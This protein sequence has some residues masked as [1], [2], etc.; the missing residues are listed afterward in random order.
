[1]DAFN[2]YAYSFMFLRI[3]RNRRGKNVYEY[4]QICERYRENG[5][6][7]TKILEYLGPVRD[8]SDMERYRRALL[9]AGEKQSIIR[10]TPEGVLSS[11]FDGVWSHLCLHGSDEKQW[12]PQYIE[13]ECGSI[14][15]YPE[16]HDY[17]KA[18]GT[19]IRALPHQHVRKDILSMVRN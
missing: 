4:A 9:L 15:P 18:A 16:L 5:K 11:A 17:C 12:H 10:M 2:C 1:M 8:E 6:Q 7:K 14:F 3:S 13:K 19:V